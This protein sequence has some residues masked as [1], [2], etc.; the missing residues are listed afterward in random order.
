M[1][2]GVYF[3]IF[4]VEEHRNEEGNDVPLVRDQESDFDVTI[5]MRCR[6]IPNTNDTGSIMVS[7]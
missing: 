6:I 7:I 4:E 3:T 5:S 2:L 1:D